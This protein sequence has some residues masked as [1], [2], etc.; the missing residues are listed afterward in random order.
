MSIPIRKEKYLYPTGRVLIYWLIIMAV[1]SFVSCSRTGSQKELIVAGS[2]S[3]QPFADRWAEIYM[4]KYPG[5][6]VNV[7]GGGSSAGIQAAHSGAADIGTSSRELKPEEKDLTEIVVAR[8]GLAIIVHPRNA[9]SDMTLDQVKQIFAGKIRNWS[10]LKGG[11]KGITV[12]TREEVPGRAAPFRS[13]S[14]VKS[15]S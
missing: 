2:T 1:A 4:K 8:D 6:V 11:D 5:R 3:V 12:V 13:W 15:A 7:Q 9:V 10:E 14:W